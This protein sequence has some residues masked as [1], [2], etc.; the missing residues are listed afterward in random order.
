MAERRGPTDQKRFKRV[1]KTDEARIHH[2]RAGAPAK[3]T[4]ELHERIISL[5][6]GG[7]YV[8]TAAQASGITPGT[9]HDWI[10]RGGRNDPAD[11]G[12]YPKFSKAIEKAVGESEAR[13]VLT[14]GKAAERQWQ[15]AAWRLE[16]K[17]FKKWGRK[18]H[19]EIAGD[20]DKPLRTRHEI[21]VRLQ[22][23]SDEELETLAALQRK[24][25]GDGSASDEGE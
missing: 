6:R 10:K 4:T 19:V 16:R 21:S 3:L 17:N 13:D 1:R 23:L 25:L 18:D 9:L 20:Q 14:I 7:N 8:E 11:G 24:A 22:R 5:V 2:T 15:A 12:I